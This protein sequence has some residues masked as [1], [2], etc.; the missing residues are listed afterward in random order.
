MSRNAA[1]LQIPITIGLP[2]SSSI[3]Y[4]YFHHHQHH[5]NYYYYYTQP[6]FYFF[7][8][9]E[10]HYWPRGLQWKKMLIH[11]EMP[12]PVPKPLFTALIF[13]HLKLTVFTVRR[14]CFS[15]HGEDDTGAEWKAWDKQHLGCRR[16][17]KQL[18]KENS[19]R[20]LWVWKK[21]LKVSIIKMKPTEALSQQSFVSCI[22]Y[23]V[24]SIYLV[25][26]SPPRGAT[27]HTQE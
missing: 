13:W 16:N 19:K 8:P 3:S 12:Q 27:R 6:N 7:V 15:S 2:S 10:E 14:V 11:A 23:L 4:F 26:K 1:N 21:K 22:Q 17:K 9:R 24:F 5:C 25:H 18:I 20:A